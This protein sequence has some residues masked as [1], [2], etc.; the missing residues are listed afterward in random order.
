VAQN[1]ENASCPI[2][3]ALANTGD[4]RAEEKCHELLLVSMYLKTLLSKPLCIRAQ[5]K[6]AIE[7]NFHL[8]VLRDSFE[9]FLSQYHQGAGNITS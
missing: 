1:P 9:L 8:A 5:V 2:V 6:L 4:N 7:T 3:G